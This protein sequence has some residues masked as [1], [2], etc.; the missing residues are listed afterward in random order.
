MGLRQLTFQLQLLVL[1]L[2]L[3]HLL[4]LQVLLV[5][6]LLVVVLQHCLALVLSAV[7]LQV[8]GLHQ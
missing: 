2:L 5:Q 4:L 6:L 3:L 8:E 1:V 7:L